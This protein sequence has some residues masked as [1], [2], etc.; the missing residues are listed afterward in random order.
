MSI[1]TLRDLQEA[2]L[3][4]RDA[5]EQRDSLIVA[6]RAEGHPLR[7]IAESAGLSP[8]GVRKILARRDLSGDPAL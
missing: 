5:I 1:P 3:T 4:V 7:R 6:M 2:A 8:E